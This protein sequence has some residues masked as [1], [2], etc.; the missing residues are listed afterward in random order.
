MLNL[1]KMIDSA[2]E[3]I[4][5]PYESPGTNDRNGID[6]SGMFVKM[7]MD[8]GKWI[9]HG[10]NTIFREHCSETGKITSANDLQVGMAVFKRKP[11]TDADKGNRWYGTEPGNLSH[12]GFVT[13][14]NP[15]EITHCTSPV[16]KTDSSIG[17]WA[18]WGK[19][20][21]VDYGSDPGPSPSPDPGPSPDP[22]PRRNMYTFAENGKPINLRAKA[23]M[24]AA[25]V[26]KVP[27]GQAVTWLKDNGAGWAYVQWQW[28]KGWMMECFLIEEP[29]PEPSP[30]PTPDPSPEPEPDPD[31]VPPGTIATV[32]ANNG[33]PVKMR[34]R[35]SAGCDLY[36]ELPVG[37]EV[38]I[39]RYADNWCRVNHGARKGWY[40]M[41][42]FLGL[43]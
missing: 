43:G 25:L 2:H 20:K 4:G 28:K 18:Y 35:P 32:W 1:N 16:A 17:K 37:T 11:W 26:D 24:K 3:C 15:L 38:E 6:C 42:K 21:D 5:W 12:I 27:V 34:A 7:Y 14:V 19:L 10:C 39:V 30:E 36:D 8:Q 23:S 40:I 9:Y 41:T 33:K 31:P 29:A 22:D 13:S